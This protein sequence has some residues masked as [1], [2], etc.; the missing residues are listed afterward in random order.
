MPDLA[1]GFISWSHHVVTIHHHII[2]QFAFIFRTNFSAVSES[3][4]SFHDV[5]LQAR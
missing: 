2:H 3:K 1:I 4:S 5:L